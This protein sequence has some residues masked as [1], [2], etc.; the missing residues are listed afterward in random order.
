MNE[1]TPIKLSELTARIRD[2]L[3]S[4]FGNQAYWVFADITNYS[5]NPEKNHHYFELVEKGE[6]EVVTKISAAAWTEGHLHIKEFEKS[7]GQQFRNGI[8]VLIKVTVDYHILYGLKLTLIDIDTS[9][10][11]GELEKQKAE[12][13]SRLLKECPEFIR[14]EGDTI[15]TRN[16]GPS[17]ETSDPADSRGFLKTI[18]RV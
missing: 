5:F 1:S 8:H 15:V 14:M 10:T 17:F 6:R 7:T 4:S 3:K 13:I 12:T 18:G 11:L 16:K 2:T 9:F